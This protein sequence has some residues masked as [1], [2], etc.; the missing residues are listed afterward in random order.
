[1]TQLRP[2][3]LCNVLYKIVAKVLTNRLKTILPR[4]I[5]PTQSAFILRHLISD[6][7]LV[8]A[9]VAHYMHKR[10][11]GS[12]GLM[13]LKLD[14]NKEYDRVELRFLEAM[15][16]HMGFSNKWIK[17]IMLCVTTVTYS[18]KLNGNPV[19]YVHP[20]RGI[21]QGDPLSPYLFVIRAE[22]LLVGMA[23]LTVKPDN[24]G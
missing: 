18:F 23:I 5:A 24:R 12:N 3:S 17:M 16:S 8:A 20:K 7:Y 13:A 11:L 4:I 10:S 15:M 1:M 21:R 14:I 2:I 6:N 9:E 22:G 19:G